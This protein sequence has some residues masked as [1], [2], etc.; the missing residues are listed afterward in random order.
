MIRK[1]VLSGNLDLFDFLDWN[2]FIKP[3]WEQSG[4]GSLLIE[5]LAIERVQIDEFLFTDVTVNGQSSGQ[6]YLLAFESDRLAGSIKFGQSDQLSLDID[7]LLLPVYNDYASVDEPSKKN[8][9]L[10]DPVS[11]ELGCHVA[12]DVFIH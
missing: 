7:R 4:G 11:L 1:V 3:Y 8:W 2:E 10:D 12:Q 9:L 6:E 5:E